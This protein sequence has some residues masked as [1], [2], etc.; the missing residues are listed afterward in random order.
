[1]VLQ[2]GFGGQHIFLCTSAVSTVLGVAATTVDCNSSPSC[3][4]IRIKAS[5][6][7]PFRKV[8]FVHIGRGTYPLCAVQSP[9]SYLTIRGNGPDP[10]FL[11]RDGRLLS[12][13]LLMAWLH[14]ILSSAGMQGNFSRHS[15]RIGE[16]TVAA[17]NSIPDHQIQVLGSWFSTAYLSYIRTPTETLSKLLKLTVGVTS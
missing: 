17:R 11:F 9:F 5:K 6:K 1:M 8:C 2:L 12:R 16:A 15:F 10:L 7:D 3:F 14:R 4:R 13:S